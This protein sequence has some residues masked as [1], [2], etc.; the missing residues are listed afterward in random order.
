MVHQADA[1]WQEISQ[2]WI[3]NGQNDGTGRVEIKLTLEDG[4]DA[5]QSNYY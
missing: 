1:Q 2:I 4:D 5:I 3:S